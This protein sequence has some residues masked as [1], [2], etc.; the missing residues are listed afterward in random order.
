MRRETLDGPPW[1]SYIDPD[2]AYLRGQTASVG[3]GL[4]GGWSQSGFG[5]SVDAGREIAAEV[6][7]TAAA[8]ANRDDVTATRPVSTRGRDG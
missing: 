5:G 6:R 2:E 8:L 1:G 4:L 3:S 7:R